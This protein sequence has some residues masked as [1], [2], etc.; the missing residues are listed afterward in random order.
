MTFQEAYAKNLVEV[1]GWYG[2]INKANI[3]IP[4]AK[5]GVTVINKVMNNNKA[6]EIYNLY[7]DISLFSF[8]P[9]KDL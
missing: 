7:P 5:D 4:N 8:I 3:D 1:N 6:C 9:N 2:F